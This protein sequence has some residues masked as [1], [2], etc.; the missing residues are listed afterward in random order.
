M[1]AGTY[2]TVVKYF[3][4]I[5][6]LLNNV[7]NPLL[8][9]YFYPVVYSLIPSAHTAFL[10]LLQGNYQDYHFIFKKEVNSNI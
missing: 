3:Q 6:F 5:S 4:V 8:S 1:C 7:S 10:H 9:Y 2:H